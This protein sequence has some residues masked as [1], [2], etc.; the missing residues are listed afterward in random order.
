[1]YILYY[2]NYLPI[3]DEL[4]EKAGKDG[5]KQLSNHVEKSS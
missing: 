4:E 3:S 1:M 2:D 5:T